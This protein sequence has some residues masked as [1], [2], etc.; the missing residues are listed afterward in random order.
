MDYNKNPE[1]AGLWIIKIYIYT[2]IA[3]GTV[4]LL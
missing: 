1:L 3:N 4:T 2:A